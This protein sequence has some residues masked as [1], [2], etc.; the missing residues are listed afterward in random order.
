LAFID[1]DCLPAP[2]WL[3]NLALRF[4]AVPEQVIIGGRTLNALSDNRYAT[5]SQLV[6]D[7]GYAYLNTDPNQAR[8]FAANNLALPTDGFRALGG[9]N[10]TFPL[11]AS[12][13]RELC[14]RWLSYGYR[15]I[16]APEV[17]VFHAHELTWRTF[18]RQHF[19]YGRG[20][21]L[22]Q[23]ARTRYG[24]EHFKPDPRYYLYLL[25]YPFLQVCR[26]QAWMLSGLLF[27]SQVASVA[28]LV[29]EWMRQHRRK[30]H[31]SGIA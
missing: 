24:W 1:D 30:P 11:A 4:A 23:Q 12:E 18:W 29:S 22:L 7:V 8:F 17:L 6:V 20:A 14:G 27:V 9:F 26:R 3:Q 21:F 10:T 31:C 5:A 19:N 25:R 16:Y 15:L 2:D 13:D 28:G